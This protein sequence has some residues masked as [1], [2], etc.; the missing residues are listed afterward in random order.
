MTV[1]GNSNG[2]GCFMLELNRGRIA[3]YADYGWGLALKSEPLVLL[4]CF[5]NR[6][7]SAISYSFGEDYGL[8][9]KAS[10]LLGDICSEF[11]NL[12]FTVGSLIFIFKS[13]LRIG[14]TSINVKCVS[15]C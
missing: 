1:V 12:S 9:S 8:L 2:S 4:F 10:S 5:S 7:D 13:F 14:S 6:V 11:G 3:N 15:D